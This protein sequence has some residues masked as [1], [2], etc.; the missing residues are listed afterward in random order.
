MA[1]WTEEY[2]LDSRRLIA[3]DGSALPHTRNPFHATITEPFHEMTFV[4]DIAVSNS[5]VTRQAF[6]SGR[7]HRV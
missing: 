6:V 2:E 4:C 5:K 3:H 1:A 7:A